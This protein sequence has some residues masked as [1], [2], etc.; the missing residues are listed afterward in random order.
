VE[1]QA[2]LILKS[3]ADVDVAIRYEVSFSF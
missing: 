1:G 2:Q 3:F